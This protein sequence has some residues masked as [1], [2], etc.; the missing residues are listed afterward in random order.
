MKQFI[1]WAPMFLLLMV[2]CTSS[3]RAHWDS[4]GDAIDAQREEARKR[5]TDR[6]RNQL[7][8][9]FKPQTEGAHPF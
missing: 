1:I 9:V 7:P 5:K 8:P 6:T 4:G 3:D 2:A